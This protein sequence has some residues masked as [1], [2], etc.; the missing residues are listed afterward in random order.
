MTADTDPVSP[1]RARLIAEFRAFERSLALRAAIEMDLFTRIDSGVDTAST[2]AATSGA[3]ERGIRILCDYLTVTGHLSK[4]SDR[5]LL[6]PD[7]RL[8]LVTTSPAYIGSAV[9]FL[10]SDGN[11]RS[12]SE[13]TQAVRNG[14]ASPSAQTIPDSSAWVGF[15]RFMDGMARPVADAAAAALEM[16]SAR[17]RQVL[18]VAAGHGL[19]GLAVAARNPSAHVFALDT[20]EVLEVAARNARLAGAAPRY[21]LIPGDAFDGDFGGPYDLILM[22]NFAHHFD[23]ATN[24]A[25]FRKCHAALEPSGCL[26]LIDFVP[27]DDRV[28]PAPEAAFA[29]TMLATTSRGDAYTFREFSRMLQD[30]GFLEV[31]Q[32]DMGAAP[33]WLITAR[34]RRPTE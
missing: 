4:Q 25:L 33:K 6:P 8:Y 32:P 28:S 10:A 24:V 30:A 29:L 12:F 14:G 17:P 3:S 21:H 11:L 18:D 31:R 34:P 13:L 2:L 15:A 27:N 9:R 1:N 16:D 20:P 26:A 22:A 7:S 23:V 19:Y 5:Y